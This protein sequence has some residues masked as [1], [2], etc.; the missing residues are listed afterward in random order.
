MINTFLILWEPKNLR[1]P[2]GHMPGMPNG[3]SSPSYLIGSRPRVMILNPGS[4]IAGLCCSTLDFDN[5]IAS[6]AN[7]VLHCQFN[8]C[9][10]YIT[11]S[12]H[13]LSLV[14]LQRQFNKC[15]VSDK[16]KVFFLRKSSQLQWLNGNP[17]PKNSHPSLLCLGANKI[18]Q[19]LYQC[20]TFCQTPVWYSILRWSMELH[21]RILIPHDKN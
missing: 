6:K 12:H 20:F 13:M 16:F 19:G 9:Y 21:V 3:Q 15:M 14:T 4:S 1:Q 11:N 17:S 2:V 8:S 10:F 5:Y 7:P 18:Q